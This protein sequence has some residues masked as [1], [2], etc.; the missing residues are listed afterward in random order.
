MHKLFESARQRGV[1][2]ARVRVRDQHGDRNIYFVRDGQGRILHDGA[3]FTR[4]ELRGLFPDYEK[5]AT[6]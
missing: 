2:I 4:E 6:L 1:E 5:P 3:S